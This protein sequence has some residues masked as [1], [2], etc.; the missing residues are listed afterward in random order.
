MGRASRVAAHQVAAIN[1]HALEGFQRVRFGKIREVGAYVR[2]ALGE[3]KQGLRTASQGALRSSKQ[4]RGVVGK[5]A[6]KGPCC[7][8]MWSR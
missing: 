6:W 7:C 1:Q 8:T 4:T 3:A 2:P 5:D